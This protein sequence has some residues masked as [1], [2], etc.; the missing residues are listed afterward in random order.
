MIN[1]INIELTNKSKFEFSSSFNIRRSK[2]M[3][4]DITCAKASPL[5]QPLSQNSR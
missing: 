5:H 2:D 1:H 4:K 3:C